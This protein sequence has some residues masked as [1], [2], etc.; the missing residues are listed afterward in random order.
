MIGKDKLMV[1][2]LAGS[3]RRE[4][5]TDMV[6]EAFLSGAKSAGAE[7]RVLYVSSLQIRPCDACDDCRRNGKCIIEDDFQMVD[8]AITSAD[9]IAVA[10]P[11]YFGGVPARAKALIDRSQCQWV[12]KYRLHEPL[13]PSR[14]G[15]ARRRGFLL[16]TAGDPR[17]NF[18]GL[19]R[20]VRYFFNVYETDYVNDLIIGG[21]DNEGAITPR[22]ISE[23]FSLG[24]N[25]VLSNK[26]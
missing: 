3:P 24:K 7:T 6:L 12:R 20:T 17:A 11:L 18:E 9:V 23:A 13:I 16:S 5:N 22:A 15:F 2:G 1:L 26:D 25:C 8:V 19:K 10:V 14:A 21:V 4:G